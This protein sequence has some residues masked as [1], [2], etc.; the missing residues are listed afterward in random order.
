MRNVKMH[1]DGWV[2]LPAG[3]RNKLSFETK[4]ELEITLVDDGVLLRAARAK[5]ATA[6]IA[7]AEAVASPAAAAAVQARAGAMQAK[8]SRGLALPPGPR[9]RGGR[10]KTAGAPEPRP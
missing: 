8:A 10:R 3:V 1:Y 9:P 6:S 5:T 7:N 4:D 2:Q